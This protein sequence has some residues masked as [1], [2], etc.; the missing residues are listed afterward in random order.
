MILN[1]DMFLITLYLTKVTNWIINTF[2][3]GAGYTWPGHLALKINPKILSSK[4]IHFK[5]GL[6]FISGTN[7]KTTT[8]KLT[9]HLLVSYGVTVVHN[10]TG[11]NLLNG[12]VSAILLDMDLFGNMR[13]DYGVFEI[14]EFTL[15]YVLEQLVPDILVLL[16][17]SRDQLDRY[18]EVDIILDR[19]VNAITNISSQPK[20][21]VDST[22]HY[23]KI[24]ADK[25]PAEKLFYFDDS[26]ELLNK[27]HLYGSFN[28]KN[29]NAAYKT[30]EILGLAT[31]TLTANLATFEVA[32]GRGENISYKGKNFHLFLAKNP[33]SFNHNLEMLLNSD[34]AFEAILFC[35]ND[36]IP[37]GRD[38]SWIYDIEADFLKK[39]CIN[40]TIYVSGTRY[41]D[42]SIRLHYAGITLPQ[43]QISVD[44]K[45]LVHE[46]VQNNQSNNILVLPNY[47]AMLEM[48]K[49]FLGRSI[50]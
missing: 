8:S 39:A 49:H 28:A 3:L 18:G 1:V 9:T 2:N 24:F 25:L 7:G 17:L 5:K 21:L 22:Q 36:N 44:E 20:L 14:D 19:W 34:L 43:N 15:P 29:V 38:V 30:C 46:I 35:L 11:A 13:S 40:K 47:S 33:A 31:T 6:V 4:R 27:T 37:D 45:A 12:L 26:K 42:M 50:L 16:N 10:K 32:Y 48:R 23:F 41:L